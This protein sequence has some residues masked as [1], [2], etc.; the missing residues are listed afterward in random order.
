M[1][2]RTT[3]G[4]GFPG[5]ALGMR[6]NELLVVVL[7]LAVVVVPPGTEVLSSLSGNY[8]PCP[9]LAPSKGRRYITSH[10]VEI[11]VQSV[12]TSPSKSHPGN[13]ST[14]SPIHLPHPHILRLAPRISS[15]YSSD[16]NIRF[17][18]RHC[19]ERPSH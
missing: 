2:Q 9:A 11:L 7:V 5:V 10:P 3:S 17:T 1:Q 19:T 13:K 15:S 6:L 12:S 18:R 8:H 4:L 14:I 16:R